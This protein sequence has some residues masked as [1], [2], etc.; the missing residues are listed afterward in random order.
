MFVGR[1]D[2]ED[3]CQVVDCLSGLGF[4]GL[5]SEIWSLLAGILHLGNVKFQYEDENSNDNEKIDIIDLKPFKKSCE[6]FNIPEDRLRDLL[7]IKSIRDAQSRVDIKKRRTLE[8]VI[9]ARDALC[10]AI[11]EK[12]FHWLVCQIN[13]VLD[14]KRPQYQQSKTFFINSDFV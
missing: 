10:K 1:D 8:D 5:Q 7:T 12:L 6:L 2:V 13:G 9:F 3:F 14:H 11:Y 4:N